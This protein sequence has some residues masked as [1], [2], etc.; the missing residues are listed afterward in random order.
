MVHTFLSLADK[1]L[2]NL[3][4]RKYGCK[5]QFFMPPCIQSLSENLRNRF[6]EPV[7]TGVQNTGRQVFG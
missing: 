5:T 2:I 1:L 3:P 7:K 4:I 6:R